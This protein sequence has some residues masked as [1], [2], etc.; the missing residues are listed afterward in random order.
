MAA[1][2][3]PINISPSEISGTSTSRLTELRKYTITDVFADQYITSTTK[4]IDGV[5]LI[6]S[7]Y[8]QYVVYYIGGIKYVDVLS[9]TSSGITF[10]FFVP[11]GTANGN[12]FINV[13]YYKNPNKDNIISNPKIDN[14]VF[15]NR[16]QLSAFEKNYRLEF[17]SRLVELTTYAGGNYFNIKSNT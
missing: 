3:P 15:I 11:E 8:P 2:T 10:N 4:S 5:N 13:P 9:G 6:D 1:Q 17:I 12:N 14:D 7:N 16:Q